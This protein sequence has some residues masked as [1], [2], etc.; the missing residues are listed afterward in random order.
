[1]R[2]NVKQR[3][4]KWAL[5]SVVAHYNIVQHIVSDEGIYMELHEVM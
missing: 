5:Y 3:N 4:N 2:E 1:M